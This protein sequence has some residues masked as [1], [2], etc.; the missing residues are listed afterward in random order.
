M[1]VGSMFADEVVYN[2]SS[3]TDG[4]YGLSQASKWS[5][6]WQALP[7][8][9][10][11]GPVSAE[12][13]CAN[14]V[15][16]N[17]Q[18][19]FQLIKSMMNTG[20]TV[21][22]GNTGS[23]VTSDITLSSS[24]GNI[25][26]VTIAFQWPYQAASLKEMSFNDVVTSFNNEDEGLYIW[27][28]DASSVKVSFKT[29]VSVYVKTITVEYAGGGASVEL[30]DPE[31]G[32]DVAEFTYYQSGGND[33]FPELKNPHGVP[34]TWNSSDTDVA[35]FMGGTQ[36]FAMAPGETTITA[37]SS[38][39]SEYAASVASYKLIVKREKVDEND[40]QFPETFDIT[41]D[42]QSATWSSNF[43]YGMLAMVGVLQCEGNSAKVTVNTPEGW[44]GVY[45]VEPKSDAAAQ[46]RVAAVPTAEDDTEYGDWTDA[47]TMTRK[48]GGVFSNTFTVP[49]DGLT[50]EYSIY[51]QDTKHGEESVYLA[52]HAMVSVIAF[53]PFAAPANLTVTPS[54]TLNVEVEYIDNSEDWGLPVISVSALVENNDPEALG[55]TFDM[56]VGWNAMYHS[57]IQN[58]GGGMGP[59]LAKRRVAAQA[60]EDDDVYGWIPAEALLADGYV[61]ERMFSVPTSEPGIFMAYIMLGKD[62]QA[63]TAKP[64]IFMLDL[65]TEKEAEPEYQAKEFKLVV[66]GASYDMVFTGRDETFNSGNYAVTVEAVEKDATI[67]IT[68]GEDAQYTIEGELVLNYDYL[69]PMT[70]LDNDATPGHL[71]VD[72]VDVTFTFNDNPKFGTRTISAQGTEYVWTPDPY[73]SKEFNLVL[74][75]MINQ[76]T[77]DGEDGNGG[78]VYSVIVD[79]VSPEDTIVIT[80]G[81]DAFY[82]VM[83]EME[84]NSEWDT[85]L[86]PYDETEMTP[87]HLD[88]PATQVKF[89]FVDNPGWETWTLKAAGTAIELYTEW[90]LVTDGGG[91]INL[92]ETYSQEADDSTDWDDFTR[93]E[94]NIPMLMKDTSFY[95]KN[96]K[97]GVKYSCGG[98]VTLNSEWPSY[99]MLT[100]ED[101]WSNLNVNAQNVVVK[102]ENHVSWEMMTLNITGAEGVTSE[103]VLVLNNEEIPFNVKSADLVNEDYI[104]ELTLPEL[105]AED[106][107]YIY[108]SNTH[109]MYS[110][111]GEV[112]VNSEYDAYLFW[113]E[114][115][116]WMHVGGTFKNVTINFHNNVGWEMMTLGITGKLATSGEST[117][118]YLKGN[119]A[120]NG[121]G[122]WSEAE[123]IHAFDKV[124]GYDIWTY[125]PVEFGAFKSFAIWGGENKTWYS[126]AS[127]NPG[128]KLPSLQSDLHHDAYEAAEMYA[129]QPAE[130]GSYYIVLDKQ[131]ATAPKIAMT[132]DL[133]NFF[134]TT[135]INVEVTVDAD[136]VYYDLSGNM[137]KNPEK[138]IYIKVANG[139]A[140]RVLI[141]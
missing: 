101:S 127:V 78:G 24:A 51:L 31:L 3:P 77:F 94:A 66:G 107:F 97:T 124:N 45:Y 140:T 36:L 114:D 85:Y 10:T 28:G 29:D 60:E 121:N 130:Q 132:R 48:I 63:A 23:S 102:F 20:L 2:F 55:F 61:D 138:G 88:T 65:K 69:T 76:M 118:Y 139:K 52:K 122:D 15:D 8:T 70:P 99:L 19:G 84:L 95:L 105:S 30:R 75:G 89:T 92:N 42:A 64:Y 133:G 135:G 54:E 117:G 72:A 108:N 109:N 26:G 16:A 136:T 82:T 53:P 129:M 22:S 141:K 17:S 90:V 74:G 103:W 125:G 57:H 46:S 67:V 126:T 128:W 43:D 1:A 96:T 123:N 106:E 104:Y 98:E 112:S 4:L 110:S 37:K 38:A 83:G 80:D 134:L 40:V 58:M 11:N 6:P 39:T 34:V 14:Y 12:L 87:G 7:H 25:T 59:D 9:M 68:D 62:G 27:N 21:K 86:T 137:V 71:N 111:G 119:V 93:Y 131:N 47:S 79:V 35:W 56:P 100:E 41:T 113:T 91:I 33:P 50:Y 13:S 49:A 18:Y 44:T 120:L 81:E 32:F 116:S 115:T 73:A 5:D